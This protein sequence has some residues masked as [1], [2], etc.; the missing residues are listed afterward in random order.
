[1]AAAC[2]GQM[3]DAEHAY[4]RMPSL[5]SLPNKKSI[6]TRQTAFILSAAL[7][8]EGVVDRDV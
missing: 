2:P 6:P 4:P 3:R 1:M 5:K 8:I 7:L